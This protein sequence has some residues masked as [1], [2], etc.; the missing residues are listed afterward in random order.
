MF[1]I[2]LTRSIIL[3]RLSKDPRL[4]L[5]CVLCHTASSS[6]AM[7]GPGA[8]SSSRWSAQP[9]YASPWVSNAASALSP[10]RRGSPPLALEPFSECR[11]AANTRARPSPPPNQ[12]LFTAPE[13]I[14]Y[15]VNPFRDRK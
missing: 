11:D 8:C 2:V 4:S 9:L 6:S 15:R 14:Y 13:L 12:V 3:V 7:R 5:E 10:G 1:E